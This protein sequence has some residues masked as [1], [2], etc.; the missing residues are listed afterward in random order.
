M[1]TTTI[2]GSVQPEQ[3]VGSNISL[4]APAYRGQVTELLPGPGARTAGDPL[5]IQT[6][7]ANADAFVVAQLSVNLSPPLTVPDPQGRSPAPVPPLLIMPKRSGVEYALLQ[8]GEDGYSNWLFP[9]TPN[10][11][12]AIFEISPSAKQ[13]GPD[14][15]GPVTSAMRGIVRVVGWAARPLLEMGARAFAQAWES[16]KRPYGLRQVVNG[17]L[18]DPNWSILSSGPVLLLVHGTFSTPEAAF[19]G[20]VGTDAFTVVAQRYSDRCLALSHPSLS[21]SPDDNVDWMLKQLPAGL[22]GPVDIVCHSR[23]GLV[24]R[25]IAAGDRPTVRRICQ[26]GAPNVG[27]PLAQVKH[28]ISFLD[29]HTALLSALPDSVS[30]IMLEAL[31]C[32][33]KLVVTGAVFGLPGLAAMEPEGEYLKTL[34]QRHLGKHRWFTIGADYQPAASVKSRFVSR[35]ADRVVDSFFSSAN[36]LVVPSDGCHVPGP[37]VEASLRLAGADVHH[38][39]YFRDTTVHDQLNAWLQ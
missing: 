26:V 34:G 35:A 39:N 5:P 38:C 37:L 17:Q 4:L 11:T 31:L 18:V 25:A 24:A 32:L 22:E 12:E 16:S 29:G 6:A 36:D 3:L 23:G 15:R 7:A 13:S 21:A 33:V 30:T 10:A 28:I 14:E 2:Q 9:V 8:T 19:G 1:P 27:T 20:W